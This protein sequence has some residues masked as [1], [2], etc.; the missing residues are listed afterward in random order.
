MS[1]GIAPGFQDPVHDA[2]RAFRAVL[3]ALARP[4]RLGRLAGMPAAPGLGPAATAVALALTDFETPVWLDGAAA[5]AAEYLRFHCGCPLV[6]ERAAAAFGFCAEPAAL[7]GLL[8]FATGSDLYPE[9]S[10]TLV[11]EV[12]GLAEDGGL[13]LLGPGIQRERRL[14]IAGLR[15]GVWREWRQLGELFPRG[16]DLILTCGDTLAALPRTVKVED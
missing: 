14:R 11:I 4:G 10:A 3:D 13:R 6:D 9:Q 16:V 12:D 8:G 5:A 1:T 15:E 7:P 2:Q